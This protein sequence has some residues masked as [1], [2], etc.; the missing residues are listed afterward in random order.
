MLENADSFE[1]CVSIS[2]DFNSRF[3][4]ITRDATA[5]RNYLR[6]SGG[7]IVPMRE[8]ESYRRLPVLLLSL[9]NSRSRI[10]AVGRQSSTIHSLKTT[11]RDAKVGKPTQS[12]PV[13]GYFSSSNVR[14]A[15]ASSFSLSLLTFG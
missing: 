13:R 10:T 11:P 6:I 14:L 4:G 9:D 7:P 12:A 15:A 3:R 8:L 2:S 5:R 1:N